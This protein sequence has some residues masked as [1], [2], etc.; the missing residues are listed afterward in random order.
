[1]PI[2]SYVLDHSFPQILESYIESGLKFTAGLGKYSNWIEFES[3]EKFKYILNKQTKRTF[4]GF[5]KIRAD[6]KREEVSVLLSDLE[7]AT[8]ESENNYYDLNLYS[9]E[10]Y[11]ELY[12]VDLNSAYLQALLN[13]GLIRDETKEWIDSRLTKRERLVAVGM[14]AKQKHIC[15]FAGGEEIQDYKEPSPLRFVFNALVQDVNRVMSGVRRNFEEDFVFYWVDGI[16]MKNEFIALQVEEYFNSMGYPCKIEHLTD[17]KSRNVMAHME[18]TFNKEGE[19]KMHKVPIEAVY[20]DI[21]RDLL[22]MLK[23]KVRANRLSK[24]PTSSTI[25]K[26]EQGKLNL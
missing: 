11:K 4:I 8:I 9:N 26:H 12:C 13:L 14:L 19:K 6:L 7:D 16:Y 1:M 15:H 10:S 21:R 22:S 18:Y 25:I 20:S 24:V 17:F 2:T 23:G 3:G 5:N